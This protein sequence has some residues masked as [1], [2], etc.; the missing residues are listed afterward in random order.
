MSQYT[1]ADLML[2][3]AENL[4]GLRYSSAT[5]GNATTLTDTSMNEP[6]DYFNGGTIFFLSGAL[7]GKTAVITDWD[8]TSHIFT[9]AT[10]SDAVVSGI[11]YA[12]FDANYSRETLIKVINQALTTH[13]PYP[14]IT[15]DVTFV[16]VADQEYY[17]LPTGVNNVKKVFI[18]KNLTAPYEFQENT[19]W[20]EEN[21]NLWFDMDTPS[22]SGYVIRLFHEAPHATVDG[23]ADAISDAIHPDLL[24]WSATTKALISR[25]G[26][27]ENSEPFTKEFMSYAQQ[28]AS[29]QMKM[30]PVKHFQKASRKSG[31]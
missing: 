28:M 18:A 8:L 1:L 12:V 25:M 20:F 7:I 13:G 23:D 29:A 30:H 17:T 9:F 24:S 26:I 10:Q 19:G 15:T 11:S 4:K 22:E 14:K 16:T 5:C 3:T 21:G 31:W 6:D 27:A 2:K